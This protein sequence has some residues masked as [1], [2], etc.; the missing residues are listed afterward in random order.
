M[1]NTCISVLLLE[2]YHMGEV[3][4][5]EKKL[6]EETIKNDKKLKEYLADLDSADND[7]FARFPRE[8]IFAAHKLQRRNFRDSL[9]RSKKFKVLT[10]GVS[11]AALLLIVFIPLYF[12]NNP[13]K[14]EFS[15]RIKG[16]GIVSGNSIDLSVYL[17]ENTTGDIIKLTDQYSIN[18]GNTVQLVYS[19]YENSSDDKYG[20]IFSIDGRSV[21][22]MHYPHT[23]WQSS[24]LDRGRAVPLDE[25][26]TLD[27]APDYEI[28]FFIAA[29]APINTGSILATAK[30]LAVQINK[31][32]DEALKLGTA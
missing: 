20:V 28:F 26:F 1:S 31:N 19:V 17:K 29:N 5:E 12:L 32:P 25:A 30:Q 11:A 9:R 7:F 24:L 18:E 27:D 6:I 15:E 16:T 3:T 23:S 10:V 8:R 4:C 22:T 21:I 13:K 2:R 14:I